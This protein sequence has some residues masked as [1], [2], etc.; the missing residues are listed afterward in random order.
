M[1]IFAAASTSQ[2]HV[3][4][5][6]NLEQDGVMLSAD[7][8]GEKDPT[9]VYKLLDINGYDVI[10]DSGGFRLISKN[11]KLNPK[12]IIQI[13]EKYTKARKVPLDYPLHK[14]DD[15]TT[16]NM[17]MQKSLENANLWS[18]HF[19][20]EEV[21][22]VIHGH[23]RE[24][25][26]NYTKEL[27][28]L[29]DNIINVGLGSVALFSRYGGRKIVEIMLDFIKICEPYN[30]H[31]FGV[32]NS[33]AVL[34]KKFGFNSVDSS[35]YLQDS[36]FGLVRHPQT[37]KMLVI[38]KRKTNK[39]KTNPKQFFKLGCTCKVCNEQDR[40]IG[41]W[42]QV[43]FRLRACHNYYTFKR[44]VSEGIETK[45]YRKA[46]NQVLQDRELE[47]DGF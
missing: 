17:K 15:K 40:R 27:R 38:T 25:L 5:W 24:E 19:D 42:G 23:D 13:Q 35:S 10:V 22:Y 18:Q 41:S 37:L 28:S 46:V 31:I 39:E 6:Y 43:G 45:R 16:R 33:G 34:A 26:E 21:I 20:P 8:L 12:K 29:V 2:K 7:D 14:K 47:I 1:K 32:G 36:R 3:K 4:V 44:M 9:T 11:K 30:Q